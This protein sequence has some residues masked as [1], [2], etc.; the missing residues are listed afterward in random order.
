MNIV[1]GTNVS[2]LTYRVGSPAVLLTAPEYTIEPANAQID[3]YHELGPNTPSFVTLL[4]SSGPAQIQ[5]VT[6]DPSHTGIYEIDIQYT[7]RFSGLKKTDTFVLTVSCVQQISVINNIP[8]LIYFITDDPIDVPVPTYQIIPAD[9][10]FELVMSA[11]TLSNGDSLPAA[12][13]FDGVDAIDIYETDYIATG[14]YAVMVTMTDPKSKTKNTDLIFSV[15]VKC[16]KSID[17]VINNLPAVNIFEI[18][19]KLLKSLTLT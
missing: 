7:D 3:S 14:Q 8:P 13:R 4:G 17:L 19:E 16:T 5:I 12:I 1:T 6:T 15:T 10:P 11:V 9:C 2:D 18:D